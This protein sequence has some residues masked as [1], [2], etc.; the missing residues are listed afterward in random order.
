MG[1]PRYFF[2][3]TILLFIF[4]SHI[5]FSQIVFKE[6]PGYKMN[7][8]DSSFFGLSA[9]RSIFPLNGN[10]VVYSAEDDEPKKISVTVPS[11]FKGDARLIFEKSFNLTKEQVREKKVKLYFLGLNY[12]ADVIVNDI[13][14]YR[15]RG[16]EYPFNVELPRE[17]LHADKSNLITVNIFYEL[18]SENTIPL[19]Q[20]FLFPSNYGGIIR[21]VYLYL[22]GQDLEHVVEGKI[23]LE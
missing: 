1:F 10:W 11:I 6:L 15:H 21:D 13:V 17:I 8:S 9:T 7:F 3:L 18:D 14:V 12:I 19:K 16:G 22:E 23:E 4:I 2:S 5:S 20:R